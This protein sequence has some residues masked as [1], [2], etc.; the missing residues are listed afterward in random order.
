MRRR[1][2]LWALLVGFVWVVVSR[3]T[4]VQ[5]LAADFS[6]FTCTLVIGIVYLFRQ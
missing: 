3:F 6:A 5:V 2:I 4:E 1:W